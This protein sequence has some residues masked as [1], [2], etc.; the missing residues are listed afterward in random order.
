MRQLRIEAVRCSARLFAL[1][2]VI[3]RLLPEITA[4]DGM[5]MDIGLPR[6]DWHAFNGRFAG[7]ARTSHI[8]LNVALLAALTLLAFVCWKILS[9]RFESDSD[10]QV[11]TAAAEMPRDEDMSAV[12]ATPETASPA[13]G[14]KISG[15]SMRRGGLGSKALVTLTIRNTNDYAVNDIKIVCA[16]TDREGRYTTKRV[17]AINDTV[18]MKSRKTFPHL[19][20]GFVSV[21]AVRSKCTLLSANRA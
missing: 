4:M 8:V 19:L 11:M 17:R 2:C 14:L 18:N 16:F 1:R 6:K 9:P 13:D 21:N 15:A 5:A 20:V 10:D 3:A 7:F 12:S